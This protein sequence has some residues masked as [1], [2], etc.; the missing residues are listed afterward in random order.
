MSQYDELAAR[1]TQV[2]LRARSWDGVTSKNTINVSDIPNCVRQ[3]FYKMT[4]TPVDEG[5]EDM[6]DLF[7]FVVS[8]GNMF[9]SLIKHK[10]SVAGKYGLHY[11]G[12]VRLSDAK[13]NVSGVTDP[14]CTFEGENI[15][16]EC[17]ATNERHYNYIVSMLKRGKPASEVTE[18]Y[19]DQLQMYLWLHPAATVGMEIIGNRNMGYSDKVPPFIVVPVEK[20]LEWKKA[21]Y[22]RLEELNISLKEKTAPKQ[23]FTDPEDYPC[24]GCL[25]FNR[26]YGSPDIVTQPDSTNL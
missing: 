10:L 5:K 3:T 19:Y 24:K 8:Y 22:K 11:G 25:W 4:K 16:T 23:E 1:L 26:C 9:E 21:N 18:G 13:L 15:I 2:I 17:K 6:S 12:E 14:C 20:D 7:D